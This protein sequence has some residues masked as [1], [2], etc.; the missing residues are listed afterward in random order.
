MM[1]IFDK[2]P[3]QEWVESFVYSAIGSIANIEAQR[4]AEA[5]QRMR[6]EQIFKNRKWTQATADADFCH[7]NDSIG[8]GK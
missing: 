1:K 8:V 3:I 5:A 7:P 6:M 4:K 2:G